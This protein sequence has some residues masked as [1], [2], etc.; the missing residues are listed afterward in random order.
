M[1]GGHRNRV[2]M[3]ISKGQVLHGDET[4]GQI[5]RRCSREFQ[6]RN[7]NSKPD[8]A[9]LVVRQAT[10]RICIPVFHS[11]FTDGSAPGCDILL[12]GKIE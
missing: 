6:S 2:L 1:L 5:V 12:Q 8:G 9:D 10:L 4:V 11:K 3:S 7:S